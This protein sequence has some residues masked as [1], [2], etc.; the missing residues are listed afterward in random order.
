MVS[1]GFV[2]RWMQKMGVVGPSATF[3]AVP[4]FLCAVL[5]LFPDPNGH[6]LGKIPRLG[7]ETRQ[8]QNPPGVG[9]WGSHTPM[10]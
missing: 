2:Q 4:I 8:K 7:T 1:C 3:N 10:S 9:A 6:V 5:F